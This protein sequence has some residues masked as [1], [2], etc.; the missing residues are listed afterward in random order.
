VSVADHQFQF[1]SDEEGR[2]KHNE[3]EDMVRLSSQNFGGFDRSTVHCGSKNQ[4]PDTCSNN[5][6]KY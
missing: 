5:F 3:N 2:Q 4:T 1:I 6:N